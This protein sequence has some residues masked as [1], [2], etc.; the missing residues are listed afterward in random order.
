MRLVELNPNW[1]SEGDGRS[2]QGV[3][4]QCPVHRGVCYLAVPFQNPI[5]GGLR[6]REGMGKTRDCY[7]QRTGETFDTLTLTPSI[8]V[9]DGPKDQR[10]T[11]W[12]GHIT[13][14]DVA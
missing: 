6:M 11:H 12:H 14:G 8:H 7:W 13:E 9:L 4:F 2:G 5:D 3:A 10:T 1:T